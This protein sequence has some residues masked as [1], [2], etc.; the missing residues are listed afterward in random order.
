MLQAVEQHRALESGSLGSSSSPNI[1]YGPLGPLT[2]CPRPQFYH[3]YN[4][5]NNRA[6]VSKGG[7]TGLEQGT[8]EP[9]LTKCYLLLFCFHHPDS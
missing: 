7:N 9:A 6:T 1:Y 3:L 4:G 8:A 5:E 2:Q